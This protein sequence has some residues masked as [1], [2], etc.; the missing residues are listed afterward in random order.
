MSRTSKF[1]KLELSEKART[2][3]EATQERKVGL[4]LLTSKQPIAPQDVRLYRNWS[5]SSEWVR[6]A[7]NHRKTQI[8]SAPWDIMP[9]D[10][11]LTYDTSLQYELVNLFEHPNPKTDS[12]RPFIES[13]IE[14][15]MVLDAG[16]IENVRNLKGYP[17][18]LWPTDGANIRLSP[19]WS[20]EM[21][22]PRYYWYPN[23][24]FGSALL[25]RDLMYIMQN[26]RT[27]TPLGLSPL[28]VLR[29]TIDAEMQAARY[30]KSQVMQAPPSGIIDLGEDATPEN[31]DQF[32]RYWRNEIAGQQSTAIVGGTKNA[33]FIP[34][35]KTNRDMQYLQWQSYLIRKIAAVYQISPQ[36]LGILFD[37]NRANAE[38]QAEISEDRGLR[39]LI[40]LL[41]SHFNREVVGEYARQTAKKKYWHGEI[42]MPQLRMAVGMSYLDPRTRFAVY[43]SN[44]NSNVM[45]LCFKFKIPSGRNGMSRAEIH[46]IELGGVPYKA[47]N[48]AREDELYDPVEGGDEIVVMT[49]IG[50]MRLSAIQGAVPLSPVENAF[51]QHAIA[52]DKMIL[53]A[54]SPLSKSDKP[55]T[56]ENP[57]T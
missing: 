47:V 44:P 37:V 41:E 21:D 16:A 26:P 7:I 29:E 24:R 12:F 10:A 22:E 19:T 36:D 38:V 31:V 50:P 11:S 5:M 40:H 51:L 39:P 13:V 32:S 18:Q 53:G 27:Y 30:N 56:V 34:F 55:S 28:Q 48:E 4:G 45:N 54:Q 9:I 1:F 52:A 14:D 42:D 57:S 8:S 20:G 2:P 15:I 25:D 3:T 6:A 43:K 46:K 35:G 49:P 17:K 23:G 33:K